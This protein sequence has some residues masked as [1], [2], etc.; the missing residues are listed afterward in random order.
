[1][2]LMDVHSVQIEVQA[3]TS[4]P[5]R[6]VGDIAATRVGGFPPSEAARIMIGETSRLDEQRMPVALR[7]IVF[8]L[9]SVEVKAQFD[10]A[11][12][13]VSIG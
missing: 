10:P 2:L 3:G 13:N 7:L 11:L 5:P 12:R 6:L 9:F 1:M 4:P 8:V